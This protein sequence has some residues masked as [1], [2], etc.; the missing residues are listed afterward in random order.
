MESG[1]D[2]GTDGGSRFS[3]GFIGSGAKNR[4]PP[5]GDEILERHTLDQDLVVVVHSHRLYWRSDID[6]LLVD[7]HRMVHVTTMVPVTKID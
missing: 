7:S 4:L 1:S 5:A 3:P 2:S 6:S